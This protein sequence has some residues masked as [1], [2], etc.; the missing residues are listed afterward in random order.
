ME[1]LMGN[2][3]S[4]PVGQ[5]I[6]NATGSSLPAED[7]AL[8]MEICDMI[9]SSEEGPRDAVRALKKR[10][11]GNKNFKEVMLALTV[12]E[13]CVKNCGYRFHILVTTRDFVEGVLVRA[14][15]PRNNPPLVLHDRVLSIVQVK[16]TLHVWQ[17]RGSMG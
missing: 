11:M 15:I 16:A 4:T 12:L 2:P 17:H 13:T 8:N 3:F 6:E 9:N 14:I 5:R 1:F 7:W 10:I